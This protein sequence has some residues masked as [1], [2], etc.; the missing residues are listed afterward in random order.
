MGS[1]KWKDFQ[2]NISS[3]FRR[4]RSDEELVSDDQIRVSAHRLVLAASSPYFRNILRQSKHSHLVLCLEGVDSLN[5]NNLLDYIYHGEAQIYQEDLGQF[6]SIAQKYQPEGLTNLAGEGT[7]TEEMEEGEVK[8]DRGPPT[9]KENTEVERLSS[10]VSSDTKATSP[11]TTEMKQKMCEN[12][13]VRADGSV[14]CPVCGKTAQGKRARDIIQHHMK[15]HQEGTAFNC[16]DC[17]KLFKSKASL[18][19]HIS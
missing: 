12:V 5:L 19:S 3:S 15:S 7:Q 18:K 17:G 16:Q 8:L 1:L 4:L 9:R 13:E 10:K 14:A 6:L 11:T 2:W